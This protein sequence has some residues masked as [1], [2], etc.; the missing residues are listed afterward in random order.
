[1]NSATMRFVI[2]DM[3]ADTVTVEGYTCADCRIIGPAVVLGEPGS[4]AQLEAVRTNL[5][6][7]IG[8]PVAPIIRLT[9]CG[10]RPAVCVTS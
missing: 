10:S 1:M 6:F 3:T 7:T 9:T 5:S 4:P 8:P 2:A